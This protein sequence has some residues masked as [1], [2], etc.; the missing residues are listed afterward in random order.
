MYLGRLNQLQGNFLNAGT[1]SVSGIGVPVSHVVI[2]AGDSGI[3]QTV[4]L[5][6]QKVGEA[7]HQPVVLQTVQAILAGLPR[8]ATQADKARAF[9]QWFIANIRYQTDDDMSWTEHG[10]QWVH[11]NACRS[12]F[13]QCEPVEMVYDAPQI[14]S[15][16]YGDC[17]DQV[18]LMGS[19][20]SLAGIR[21]CPVIVALDASIPREFSH[22][23]IV[24]NLDGSWIPID[25]VNVAQPYGWEAPGAFRREVLC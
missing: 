6:R 16:R 17:D 2:G 14:L 24:A 11:V 25:T 10:L 23:Y 5:I 1:N 22:I 7:L 12:R 21:W 18:L 20:L 19:F 13:S 15:Q 9:V 4:R 8:D 3:Y